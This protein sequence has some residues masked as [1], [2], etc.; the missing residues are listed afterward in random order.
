MQRKVVPMLINGEWR[1]AQQTQ[2]IINPANTDE[3]VAEVSLGTR[4]DAKEAIEAA[5]KAFGVW[6]DA[7]PFERGRLLKK[8]ASIVRERLEEIA[9][10]LTLENGKPLK[11]A[12][13]EIEFAAKVLEYYG[14]EATRIFGEWVPT[15]LP[16]V[17]SI[18]I[19]QPIGVAGLIIPWNFPVD[20]LAWKLGPAL[21]A[22]CTVVIKPSSQAPVAATEFVRA[23]TDAGFPAGVINIVQGFSSEVGLELI[24]NPKVAKIAFTGETETGKQ[25]LAKAAKNLKRVTLEL[26]GSAPAIIC[27][28]ATLEVAV[29]S[30]VRR[31]FSHM[32]QICISINRVYVHEKVA[33]DFI[34]GVVQRTKELRIGNGLHPETDLGPMFREELRQKTREHVKD[35]VNKGAKIIYGGKEPEGQEYKKGFFFMP[36]IIVNVNHTMKIMREETFGPVMPIMVVK[37]VEEAVSLANDSEYGLA[38]YV[39]TNDLSKAIYAAERL[40]VGGVGVNINDVTE[41]QAPF[42]GWKQSG[43]GRELSRHALDNYL[44]YKHIRIGLVT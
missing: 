32:G 2:P 25:I 4:E 30:C 15:V 35:A 18:V 34:D 24:E 7:S 26:G 43:L 28:D 29:P 33:E 39:F 36:T 38:A 9:R 14:E 12:K 23:V 10:L 1:V 19:R 40:E 22:G 27:D 8:A 31:A 6:K 41:L 3:V 13:K 11:D 16:S 21:A 20:L 17:R 5:Y 37:S 44:E 42:G